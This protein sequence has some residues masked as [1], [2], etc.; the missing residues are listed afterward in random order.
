MNNT[1]IQKEF[2]PLEC[3]KKRFHMPK[4]ITDKSTVS[5]VKPVKGCSLTGFTR[6]RKIKKYDSKGFTFIELLVII[7]IIGVL[8]TLIIPMG[9]QARA[10]ARQTKAK[11]EIAA[12]ETAMSAY[13]ADMGQYPTD[14]GES[15]GNET[16]NTDIITQLSGRTGGTGAWDAGITGLADWNGPYMEFDSD[17]IVG[18]QF[19]DPWKTAYVIEIDLDG[20][21]T[22]TP[23]SNNALSFDIISYGKDGAAGGG[24]DLTNY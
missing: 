18:G 22:T 11:A 24:D 8:L 6:M 3:E 4:K 15:D 5:F 21:T 2:I 10:K 23:P 7:T 17:N 14:G 1:G 13:Y 20:D 12:L 16:D 9:S 19:I